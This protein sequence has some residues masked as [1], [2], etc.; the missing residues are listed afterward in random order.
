MSIV[1]SV[2]NTWQAIMGEE[3]NCVEQDVLGKQFYADLFFNINSLNQSPLFSSSGKMSPQISTVW[4][5]A[6]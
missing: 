3:R 1:I 5:V 6:S 2:L 4:A